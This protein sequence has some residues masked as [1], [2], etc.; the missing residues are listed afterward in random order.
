MHTVGLSLLVQTHLSIQK[1]AGETQKLPN[2][3]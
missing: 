1:K 2:E 3:A